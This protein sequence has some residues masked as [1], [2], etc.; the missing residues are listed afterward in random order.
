MSNM[1]MKSD[2]LQGGHGG[3]GS[4]EASFMRLLKRDTYQS[5]QL[6][7]PDTI[8]SIIAKAID[9]GL[10]DASDTPDDEENPFVPAAYTYLGQF[11]DHDLT[12]DTRSTLATLP[13]GLSSFP[14]DV[15]TP[16]LDM[17]CLYGLGPS[18][19]PFMYDEDG[20][21]ATNM[22]R[23]Y[24]L[25][26]STIYYKP[27]DAG[28]HRAIIGD[29]RNDENS[30]VCQLQLAF[31]HF[32]NAMIAFFKSQG[33]TG[34]TLFQTAQQEVRFTYQTIIV[35]DLLKRIV[36]KPVYDSFVQDRAANGDEAYKLYKKGDR[37]ALPL[38]F[39]GAAYR[40]GHS[41]IRNAY[42]LNENFQRRIFDGADNA[43]ESL[44]GFGDLPESHRIDWSLFVTDQLAPGTKGDNPSQVGGVDV[45][46]DKHRLQYSYKIDT[47]LVN[48][49]L[50]LPPRIGGQDMLFRSL[51]ARNL[52]RGYNFSLPSGQDVAAVLGVSSQPPLVFG[53]RLLSFKDMPEMPS[54][55]ASKLE[56]STPLWLYVLAE[57]QAC[58]AKADG[59]FDMKIEDG[60]KV[61]DKDSNAG[62]QL[63][64]VGG[65][66]VLEVFFGILDDDQS[67]VANASGWTSVI[68]PNAPTITLWDMLRYIGEV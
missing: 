31:I 2:Q 57:A 19:S 34:Q 1:K 42:R 37:T 60:V 41:A 49:L 47:S 66:I 33:L 53:E 24:D 67:S 68:K 12:F 17:D 9:Q 62:T 14:N 59:T 20:R 65:R 16:R 54:A 43:A 27:D 48:P 3:Q 52:K 50:V 25:P 10:D 6:S 22:D 64:P 51:A 21:L 32:H 23:P 36:Q 44:V 40:Y 30:I 58:L 39:T 5:L 45:G 29:P 28:S 26:R 15:R 38:E 56:D 7:D 4:D 63:G 61:A 35:T 46:P 55:D 11:I 8:V 13:P 18:A